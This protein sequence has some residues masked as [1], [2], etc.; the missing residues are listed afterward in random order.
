MQVVHAPHLHRDWLPNGLRDSSAEQAEQNLRALI[1]D[2]KRLHAQLLA[3][4]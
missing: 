1:G 2:A 4:L 3:H